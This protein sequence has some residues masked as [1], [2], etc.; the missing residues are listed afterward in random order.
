MFLWTQQSV[1]L[2]SLLRSR[3][4]GTRLMNCVPR[5][6]ECMVHVLS[7]IFLPNKGDLRLTTSPHRWQMLLPITLHRLCHSCKKLNLSYSW[8]SRLLYT[9]VFLY[10]LCVAWFLLFGGVW[11]RLTLEPR[12]GLNLASSYLTFSRVLGLEAW[13]RAPG[14]YQS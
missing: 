6:Q 8:S 11:D 9:F 4:L 14:L 10:Q 13:S 3:V 2:G 5:K 12:L 1:W 7:M